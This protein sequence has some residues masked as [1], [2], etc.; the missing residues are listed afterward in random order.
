MDFDDAR[1]HVKYLI[2][3]RDGKYPALFDALLVDAGA[4]TMIGTGLV[5]RS[6][7][8]DPFARY[9]SRSPIQRRSPVCAP[10]TRSTRRTP[11]LTRSCIVSCTDEILGIRRAGVIGIRPADGARDM[12][13]ALGPGNG[14]LVVRWGE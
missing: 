13:G 11:P 9:P 3:D 1:C 4:A 6:R 12:V 10:S 5:G 8:P 14:A 2:R 7:T